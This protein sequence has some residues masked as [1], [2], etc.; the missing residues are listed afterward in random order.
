M[1]GVWEE[2]ATAMGVGEYKLSGSA[3]MSVPPRRRK[4]S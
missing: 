2:A 1:A 4:A 3:G